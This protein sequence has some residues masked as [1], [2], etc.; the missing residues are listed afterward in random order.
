M[1]IIKREHYH[2]KIIKKVKRAFELILNFVNKQSCIIK[3]LSGAGECGYFKN[4]VHHSQ[5]GH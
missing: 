5:A 2:V 1:K 3:M 4:Y